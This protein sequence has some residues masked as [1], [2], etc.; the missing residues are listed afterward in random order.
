M[1]LTVEIAVLTMQSVA[2]KLGGSD[3]WFQN[4]INRKA[5]TSYTDSGLL[6]TGSNQ[7]IGYIIHS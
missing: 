3:S 2:G 1:A 5:I 4:V 7:I 6:D